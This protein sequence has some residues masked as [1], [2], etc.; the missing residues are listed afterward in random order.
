MECKATLEELVS[1]ISA[2]RRAE[3]EKM[4]LEV[5]QWQGTDIIQ[6]ISPAG[7]LM[8]MIVKT[9]T[10]DSV[11]VVI[12]VLVWN[13]ARKDDPRDVAYIAKLTEEIKKRFRQL[14]DHLGGGVTPWDDTTSKLDKLRQSRLEAIRGG[15]VI[16]KWT[17]ACQSAG[18]DPKTA[19]T[20]APDLRKH[21]NDPKWE[22]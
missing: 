6:F 9:L 20:H 10:V 8:R 17:T 16:P 1:W 12:D 19:R 15:R 22:E 3:G 14:P 18:I 5:Q 11:D 2:Y 21:W 13:E 7:G 4:P